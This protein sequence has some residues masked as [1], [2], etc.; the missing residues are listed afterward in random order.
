MAYSKLIIDGNAVYEID[1]E[2]MK[3]RGISL[4]ELE[5][6]IQRSPCSREGQEE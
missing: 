5:K 3:Q 6:N 1:E 2:C 4:E